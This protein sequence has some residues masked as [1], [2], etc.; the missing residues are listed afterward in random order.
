MT[1]VAFAEVHVSLKGWFDFV[2]TWGNTASV[3]GLVVAI[4]AF[5]VTWVRQRMIRQISQKA[6]QKVALVILSTA[7]EDLHRQL[8]TAMGAANEG[9]WLCALD[10]YRYARH[11]ILRLLGNMHFVEEESISLREGADDLTRIIQYIEDNKRGENASANFQRKKKAS[12]DRLVIKLTNIQARL[13]R[14]TWEV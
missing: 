4:I 1:L 13:D 3:A 7:V 8:S 12:V 11:G 14:K 2:D 5:P 6:V 10:W 9:Q